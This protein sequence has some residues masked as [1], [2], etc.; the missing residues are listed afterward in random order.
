MAVKVL[1]YFHRHIGPYP[2]KKLANV[3]SK[4][5][6]GGLENASA[7]FY[8]ESSV[9]G[10]GDHES[11]IA[12]EE[13]HQWFGNSVTEN[14]WY[15]VW[16]SEGF[17]TYFA[18]LYL[19]NAYGHERLVQEQIID[20]EQVIKYYQKNPAPI[21]DTTLT[22]INKVLSTNT[23]QKAGWVL[24]MLRHKI[25]DDNF[26]K[27]IRGYYKAYSYGNAMTEDFQ[28]IMEEASGQNLTEYFNQWL[29]KPGHPKLQGTWQY[30]A[31]KK[32]V[33][34]S[35]NQIQK[36]SFFTFPLEIALVD[37]NGNKKIE[38]LQIDSKMLKKTVKTDIEPISIVLDPN[39]WLLF[40]GTLQKK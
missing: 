34:I 18:N 1:D 37:K 10:K 6:W 21:I 4:T 23:Y 17:A 2:F 5:R 20:R 29:H 13:A 30:S 32:E 15:H 9:N 8:A 26:W 31:S 19:E 27:G 40:D 39:T 3:Q 36:E 12:H 28:K 33:T 24:H 25:G 35:L 16:L 22:D 11:L 14:D 7:I 38:T